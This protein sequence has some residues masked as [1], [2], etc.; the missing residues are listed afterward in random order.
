MRRLEDKGITNEMSKK[1]NNFLWFLT[2]L[3]PK[4]MYIYIFHYFF[5]TFIIIYYVIIFKNRV[6]YKGFLF[7]YIRAIEESETLM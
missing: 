5:F 1:T 3:Y 7:F 4:N 2:I 6:F